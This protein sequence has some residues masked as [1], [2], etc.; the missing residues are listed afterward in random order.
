MGWI[1]PLYFQHCT[2]YSTL[3]SHAE[4]FEHKLAT[5]IMTALASPKG[6]V[7]L[8]VPRDIMATPW[9]GQVSYQASGDLIKMPS[10]LD[11]QA[12]EKFYNLLANARKIVFIVGSDACSAI[13]SILSLVMH[14]NAELS[15]RLRLKGLSV[16][17]ILGLEAYLAF[18]DIVLHAKLY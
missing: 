1:P 9:S 10:L 8:T 2:R 6:P 18:Q 3:I 16:L 7:H 11:K 17:I 15:Q 13:G 4:Q 12:L 5:A 14:L